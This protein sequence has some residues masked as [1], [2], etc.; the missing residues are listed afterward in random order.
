MSIAFKLL[1]QNEKTIGSN[2]S[3]MIRWIK[4]R[5]KR[6]RAW[7]LRKKK[8]IIKWSVITF[9]TLLCCYVFGFVINCFISGGFHFKF[10]VRL[11]IDGKTF[12][13]TGVLFSVAFL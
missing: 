1:Q 9:A 7:L 13:Y 3:G 6:L 4:G 10:S 2:R 5:I 12:L 11:L 8:S